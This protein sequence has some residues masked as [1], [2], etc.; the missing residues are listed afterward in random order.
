MDAS[1]GAQ[2]AAAASQIFSAIASGYTARAAV[3][4]R[5]IIGQANAAARNTVRRGANE[6]AGAQGALARYMQSRNNARALDAAGARQEAA[7]RTIS[8]LRDAQSAASIQERLRASEDLGRLSAASAFSGV[9]GSVVEM[10]AGALATRE[11]LREGQTARN[12]DAR[13]FELSA[14]ARDELQNAVNSLDN[15][16]ILDNI[17]LTVD[18]HQNDPVPGSF[19]MDVI[20]GASNADL[21]S[22]YD[23]AAKQFNERADLMPLGDQMQAPGTFSPSRAAAETSAN[24][25]ASGG[26]FFRSVKGMIP[27][28]LIPG[29]N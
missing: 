22:I 14:T 27:S 24:A 3:R 19:L 25:L 20:G 8:R 2:A 13:I 10:V 26:D 1:T 7:G 17:D 29:G 11:S 23:F 21:G 28:F 6:I 5:N 9:T 4:T 16:A 15:R 12:E 18:R